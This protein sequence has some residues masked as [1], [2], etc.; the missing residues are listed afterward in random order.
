MAQVVCRKRMK[1]ALKV[2]NLQLVD[3]RLQTERNRFLKGGENMKVAESEEKAV[4]LQGAFLFVFCLI[5]N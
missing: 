1:I 5:L 4:Y 3:I 2:E